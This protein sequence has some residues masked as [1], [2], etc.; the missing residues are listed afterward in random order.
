MV[1]CGAQVYPAQP[2]PQYPYPS[3]YP[4]VVT[5]YAVAE[6]LNPG[7]ATDVGINMA[8]APPAYEEPDMGKPR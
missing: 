6:P 5:G 1:C 7:G 4:P 8:S 2:Q 3:Q